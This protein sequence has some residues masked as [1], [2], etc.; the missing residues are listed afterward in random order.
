MQGLRKY[1]RETVNAARAEYEEEIR[2]AE[3]AFDEFNMNLPAL[4][5]K[6][7]RKT[8]AL[9]ADLEK[10]RNLAKQLQGELD[11]TLHLKSR[12]AAA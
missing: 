3:A 7:D 2:A 11:R 6:A 8:R 12:R 4:L 5:A 10:Q 1:Q 9:R